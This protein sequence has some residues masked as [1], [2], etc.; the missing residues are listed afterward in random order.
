MRKAHPELVLL[1]AA[2]S[3]STACGAKGDDDGD[4]DSMAGSPGTGGSSGGGS[5][6]SSGSSSS[7]MVLY[8]FASAAAT[9]LCPPPGTAEGCW[10]IQDYTPG[11]DDYVNVFAGTDNADIRATSLTWDGGEG[12]DTQPG[13]LK[14]VIPFTD[15]NQLA[16]IQ[17]NFTGEA[18]PTDWSGKILRAQVMLES[19]GSSEASFPSGS[20]MFVKT[21]TEYVWAKGS[22]ANL[23]TAMANLWQ[24]LNFSLE[25]PEDTDET[26]Q[27]Y[28]SS[29]I[30]SFGAQVY[31]GGGTG[32]SGKPTEAVVYFDS[33]TL[34]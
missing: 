23:G 20:Y 33:F 6:G 21:G 25:A 15:W 2:L 30:V 31:S 22:S 29:E 5:S 9:P 17:I 34:E 28:R 11:D 10:A 26:K 7:K 12:S 19:G 1:F 8:D 13:R 3:L 27:D 16:D 24:P 32:D 18:K 14:F 4:D